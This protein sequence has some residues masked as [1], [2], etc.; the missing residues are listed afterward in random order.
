M[1]VL[2]GPVFVLPGPVRNYIWPKNTEA[3]PGGDRTELVT[4]N[5]GTIPPHTRLKIQT[6]EDET[7]QSAGRTGSHQEG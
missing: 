6:Q 7:D 2:P 1:F 4:S 5:S 3:E